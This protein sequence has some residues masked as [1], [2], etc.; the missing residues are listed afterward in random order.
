MHSSW[1]SKNFVKT[2]KTVNEK[3]VIVNHELYPD[4]VFKEKTRLK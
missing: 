2:S 1:S 4:I 3:V